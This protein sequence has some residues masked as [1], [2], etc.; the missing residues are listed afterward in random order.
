MEKRGFFETKIHSVVR[1]VNHFLIFSKSYLMD[2][3]IIRSIINCYHGNTI[4][5]LLSTNLTLIIPN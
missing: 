3:R 1:H 4:F 2:F 5:L